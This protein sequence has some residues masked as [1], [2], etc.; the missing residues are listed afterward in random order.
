M[1]RNLMATLAYDGSDFHGWQHQPGLRTVQGCLEQALRR[2]V[3]HQVLTIGCSRT[4]AG[5][6][7]A[8]HISNFFTTSPLPAPIILRGAGSRLP[9]DMSLI[10]LEEVPLTFHATRSALGKQYRYRIHAAKGRPCEH[11]TQRYTYHVWTPLDM[12]SMREAAAMWIGNHDFSSFASAGNV[13]ESNI[14]TIRKLEINREGDEIH[15]DVEGNGFLYKQ[16][17]NMVGT[18]VEIGLGKW[19]A[20]K[21]A[22]ILA[23]KDRSAAG[24][25]APA[26]GLCLQWVQ[27]D[28]ANLPKPDAAMLAR[29]A[30][31]RPPLGA[32]RA[33]VDEQERG[34]APVP[35]SFDL[36]EEPE[37]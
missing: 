21:A 28:I 22:E 13:R 35:E 15:L 12:D 2:V 10:N 6:H 17:R 37:A 31:A 25:T 3:R 29:A 27:Y 30:L 19:P 9:K 8:M 23:A 24:P 20:A 1:L 34:D 5:V 26:R 11:L 36:T 32:E 33:I 4:D 16:V 7:A 18:L 14:R